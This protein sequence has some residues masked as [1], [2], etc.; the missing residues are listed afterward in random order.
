MFRLQLHPLR[1]ATTTQ[2]FTTQVRIVSH[3]L[4]SALLQSANSDKLFI[5]SYLRLSLPLFVKCGCKI[6]NPIFLVFHPIS[7]ISM[8][9]Q[10]F[11]Y[12]T[13]VLG[14]LM[15]SCLPPEEVDT[16]TINRDLLS[17]EVKTIYELQDRQEVDSLLLLLSNRFA[18]Q[19]YWAARAFG[20]LKS[21]KAVDS[22]SNLLNDEVEAVRIAA[23]YALGQI[24]ESSAESS[25]IAAFEQEDSTGVH[26]K[27]NKT[28]LEA[29]GKTAS[30]DFLKFMST[31]QTYQA[32]DTALLEGQAL[33]IYR[34]MLRGITDLEGTRRMLTLAQNQ[35]YP[36]SVRMIAANYLLRARKLSLDTMNVDTSL[37][38]AFREAS[39]ARIRMALATALGRSKSE[40]ALRNLMEQFN[41]EEDY[42]VKCNILRAFG[43]FEY[44][45]IRDLVFTA[46]RNENHHVAQTAVE[47]LIQHGTGRD[48]N[49]YRQIA[50]DTSLAM[51]VRLGLL[52][53]ANR[54]LANYFVDYKGRTNYAL[55]KFFEESNNPYDKAAA[56]RGMAYYTRMYPFI[57]EVSESTEDPIVKTASM[58]A[59]KT[60][61]EDAQFRSTMGTRTKRAI[62]EIGDF[63]LKGIQSKEAGTMAIASEA[64][65]VKAMDFKSVLADSISI[66]E[67][68]LETLDLPKEI[69]TYNALQA[70]IDHF[71]GN[72]KQEVLPPAYN[73]PI[74][75]E[76]LGAET[77]TISTN[78][79]NIEIELLTD[80]A[81]SSVA[82]FITLS[83]EGFY[84]DKNFHRVVP[85]FVIQGGCPIGSGYG[86]LDYTIRSELPPIY[87][88]EG[89]YVGMAS[90]GNHTEGVQFF[91]THSPTP[92]LDGNYTIFAK[93]IDGMNVVHEIE[94]GDKIERVEIN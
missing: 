16:T 32:S 54:H 74:D 71:K 61:C 23:A 52:T 57:G 15:T 56:L 1:Q 38:A 36:N 69:E 31:V 82:N 75:W 78:K 86:A 85:N 72:K 18:T 39:D 7:P 60:I 49:G 28:I 58:E 27:L 88:D 59:L 6:G 65:R 12:L 46:M 42:R 41:K 93:V 81:P 35:N 79:G 67:T 22:L 70:S 30:K 3:L 20:S 53:A 63:L 73:H 2:N 77:A 34:Y 10:S 91:I 9:K 87:Y 50:R 92:H 45:R 29:V 62:T 76:V 8:M 4:Q 89:G 11:L 14:L 90:A 83:N 17:Q 13:I 21:K 5:C 55:R 80:I 40:H 51:P 24:G 43:N 25:L 26:D 33:G 37:A 19:R 48:A 47:Y 44:G 66:L 94:V 68:A 64:L 84:N